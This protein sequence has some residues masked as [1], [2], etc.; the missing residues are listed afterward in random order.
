[1]KLPRVAALWNTM[2][3]RTG[4]PQERLVGPHIGLR[5][6]PTWAAL[7][8]VDRVRNPVYAIG[9]CSAA[10]GIASSE[11]SAFCGRVGR[12]GP[13]GARSALREPLWRKAGGWTPGI[14]SLR[15]P[16]SS[17][18]CMRHT[19]G[20]RLPGSRSMRL[21][22]GRVLLTAAPPGS[23]PRRGWRTP[24]APGASTGEVSST[25]APPCAGPCRSACWRLCRWGSALARP[26]PAAHSC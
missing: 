23:D 25:C 19:P 10:G 14:G 15:V 16:S 7:L 22:A 24:G 12:G 3:E 20:G 18:R 26:R 6:S 5:R 2:C 21:P 8:I 17:P 4:R 13:Q 11:A 9:Q 1:M